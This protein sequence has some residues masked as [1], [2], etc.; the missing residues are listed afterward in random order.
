MCLSLREYIFIILLA[1]NASYC[2]GQY[3]GGNGSTNSFLKLTNTGCSV[4]NV[5]PFIGGFQD[6]YA[7]IYLTNVNCTVVNTNPFKGGSDDGHANS[8]LLNI[9]CPVINSNPFIGGNNDGH[10]NIILA[11]ITCPI[12]N[13][14]PFIGGINDGHAKTSLINISCPVINANPFLG[15]FADGHSNKYLINLTCSVV[16][17]NPFLGGINDGGFNLQLTNINC[18]SLPIELLSFNA[19]RKDS[20]VDLFWSTASE[21]NNDYFTLEKSQEGKNFFPFTYIRG[22]GNSTITLNYH[23]VDEDPLYGLSF[24]RLK[25]TDYD[26]LFTYS[27]VIRVNFND[28]NVELSPN[29]ITDFR[30]IL[31]TYHAWNNQELNI[32]MLDVVGA[33]VY[34]NTFN[35]NR[36]Q[37][38]YELTLPELSNGIYF[39]QIKSE[40]IED[41]IKLVVDRR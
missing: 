8:I 19:K 24:Y 15:G 17:T 33:V 39:V 30:K 27:S 20:H 14:N 6:G 16:N 12:V 22:A 3:Y 28:H 26:G 37:N 41:V 9:V 7:Y 18:P 31:L 11:N 40:G 25:Q 1:L 5:N 34:R 23:S 10:A 35:V 4:V 29:P 13:V 36:G 32:L 2:S 38:N 21:I